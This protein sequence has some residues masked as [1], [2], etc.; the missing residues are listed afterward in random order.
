MKPAYLYH[1]SD[2]PEIRVFHPRSHPRHPDRPPSVWAI[3]GAREA[4][5]WFP[6]NCPRV[7]FWPKP[8]SRREEVEMLMGPSPAPKVIAMESRWLPRIGKH[9]LYRYKLPASSFRLFDS[10]AGYWV[11]EKSV[12]P[13]GVEEIP[14]FGAI[15]VNGGGSSVP[16][17]VPPA[18]ESG[19]GVHSQL[20][21]DSIGQ[22]PFISLGSRF[23]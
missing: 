2:E 4:H 13:A 8:D 6:R 19:G 15:G 3:D 12:Q 9:R 23:L 7:I 17:P 18:G 5:Y 20:F 14:E 10:T 22:R 11:S 21:H 1:F 16:S